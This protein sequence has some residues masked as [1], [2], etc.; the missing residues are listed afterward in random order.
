MVRPVTT[1]MSK[2]RPFLMSRWW[3]TDRNVSN[4]TFLITPS[5]C[6]RVPVQKNMAPYVLL[7]T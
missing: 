3:R 5:T 7:S 4:R 1:R 2:R 6:V